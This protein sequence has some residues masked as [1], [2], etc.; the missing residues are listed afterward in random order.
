[1]LL[2]NIGYSFANPTSVFDIVVGGV[3]GFI[4][5]V[6]GLGI[7]SG[8]QILGSGLSTASQK[9]IFGIGTLLN[10]LFQIDIAGLTIGMGLG[11]TLIEAFVL[12]DLFGI[13]FFLVTVFVIAI[14]ISGIMT[15]V[16][17]AD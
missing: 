12:N 16:G 17:G 1:M 5:T 14:L 4:A 2:F 15:I 3:V 7:I 8:I 11:S 10:I 6:A 9:I 13:P